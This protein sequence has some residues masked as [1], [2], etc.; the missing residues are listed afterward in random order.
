MTTYPRIQQY[1]DFKK[2]YIE[3]Q[4]T[5]IDCSKDTLIDCYRE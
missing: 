5:L 3:Q 2:K 1:I 4:N